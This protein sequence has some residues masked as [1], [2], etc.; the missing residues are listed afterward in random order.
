MTPALEN[1]GVVFFQEGEGMGAGGK[2][3]SSATYS[4]SH[5]VGL[6]M[7]SAH[8]RLNGDDVFERCAIQ[9]VGKGVSGKCLVSLAGA[10]AGKAG[11]DSRQEAMQFLLIVAFKEDRPR[12][13]KIRAIATDLERYIGNVAISFENVSRKNSR[14]FE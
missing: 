10:Q 8:T 5:E 13:R 11:P 9:S 3:V 6:P 1:F 12:P 7:I 4:L 14:L 2:P